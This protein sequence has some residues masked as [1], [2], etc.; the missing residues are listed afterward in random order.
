MNECSVLATIISCYSSIKLNEED[1]KATRL[2]DNL[3]EIE[4]Q[5][6]IEYSEISRPDLVNCA[7]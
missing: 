3:S 6:E 1:K 4:S 7:D 2:N 5:I